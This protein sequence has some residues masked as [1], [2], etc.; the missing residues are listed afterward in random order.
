M[1]WDGVEDV[2]DG[3]EDV[4]DGVEDVRDGVGSENWYKTI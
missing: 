2:R 3:V 4:R 1:R